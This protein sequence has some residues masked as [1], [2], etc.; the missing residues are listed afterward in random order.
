MQT[1]SENVLVIHDQDPIGLTI[2][3][4]FIALVFILYCVI[5]TIYDIKREK[6]LEEIKR[7][8]EEDGR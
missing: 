7:S 8:F 1:V 6:R 5:S 4:F 2:L 3:L